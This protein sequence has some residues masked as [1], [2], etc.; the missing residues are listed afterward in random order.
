MEADED[1]PFVP[2]A[3]A[4]GVHVMIGR[5]GVPGVLEA[6]DVAHCRCVVVATSDD[7]ANLETA[8]EARALRPDLRVVLRLFDPD[9]AE[10]AERAFGIHRSLSVS[11]LAAPAF[12]LAASGATCTRRSRSATTSCSSRSG[13]RARRRAPGRWRR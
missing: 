7:A 12:A 6:V 9:L 5:V 8:L 10:R 3:R 4:L 2:V 13:G 11:A 1:G